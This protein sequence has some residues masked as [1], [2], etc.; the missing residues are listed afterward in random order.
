MSQMLDNVIFIDPI[1]NIQVQSI[2]KKFDVCF[3]ELKSSIYRYGTSPNKLAQYICAKTNYSFDH[4]K[5]VNA[6]YQ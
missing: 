4:G 1:K 5:I 3:V 2:L 6:V